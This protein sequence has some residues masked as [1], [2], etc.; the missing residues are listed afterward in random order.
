M[1]LPTGEILNHFALFE[2]EMKFT[3]VQK[4]AI[5]G[6]I[7]YGERLAVKYISHYLSCLAALLA[8]EMN[9]HIP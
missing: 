2:F 7:F 6:I 8:L 3:T 1:Q 9:V 5:I 4:A